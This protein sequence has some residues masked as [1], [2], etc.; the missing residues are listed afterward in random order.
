[1]RPLRAWPAIV[2]D[3]IRCPSTR[4]CTVTPRLGWNSHSASLLPADRAVVNHERAY[5]RGRGIYWPGS[6]ALLSPPAIRGERHAACERRRHVESD[7]P[8]AA[9]AAGMPP[10][11]FTVAICVLA[12]VTART[13]DTRKDREASTQEMRDTKSQC[14]N[15][16]HAPKHPIAR[17]LMGSLGRRLGTPWLAAAHPPLA[18]ISPE[19]STRCATMS[20]EPPLPPPPPEN[21]P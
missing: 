12:S 13:A 4:V 1:M 8:T 11:I 17:L 3:T 19:P 14:C 10:V 9:A 7:T 18:L 16:G 20:T 15:V 2:T 6:A 21:A 5:A